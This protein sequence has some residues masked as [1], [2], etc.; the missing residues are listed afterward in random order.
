LF[1][2]SKFL[3]LKGC[4]PLRSIFIVLGC[5][6]IR[7]IGFCMP[8]LCTTIANNFWLSTFGVPLNSQLRHITWLLEFKLHLLGFVAYGLVPCFKLKFGL[9]LQIRKPFGFHVSIL[10]SLLLNRL[11]IIFHSNGCIY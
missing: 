7:T 8:R 2:P 10:P 11:V 3:S 5:W 6:F 1:A 9:G 4:L